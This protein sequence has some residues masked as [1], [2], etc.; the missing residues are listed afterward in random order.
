QMVITEQRN[1]PFLVTLTGCTACAAAKEDLDQIAVSIHTIVYFVELNPALE[2][3]ATTYDYIYRAT[4]EGAEYTDQSAWPA[5]G[6]DYSTPTLYIM[7][8]KWIGACI[9][10]S[11]STNLV[12]YVEVQTA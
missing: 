2:D 6:E 10:D 5:I 12:R 7:W 9:T 1:I 4:N 8:Q 3:Y 11:F